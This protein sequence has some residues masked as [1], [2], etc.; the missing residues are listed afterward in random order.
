MTVRYILAIDQGTTSS[1]VVLVDEKGAPSASV[2]A[3]LR[4]IYPQSGWVE[5]DPMEIWAAVR[6]LVGSF[7]EAAGGAGAVGAIGITNQRETT[8]LWDRESG[9]PIVQRH[10]LAGPPYRRPLP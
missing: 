9:E 1:R 5:H 2:S 6:E 8:V 4:Q 10:R 7:L 3:D